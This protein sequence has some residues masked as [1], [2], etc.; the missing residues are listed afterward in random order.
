MPFTR[1]SLEGML[2]SADGDEHMTYCLSKYIIVP[3]GGPCDPLEYA[4]TLKDGPHGPGTTMRS[5]GLGSIRPG[6]QPEPCAGSTRLRVG[7]CPRQGTEGAFGCSLFQLLS[8]PVQCVHELAVQLAFRSQ[9]FVI[10]CH[11]SASAS[12][13]R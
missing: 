9:R 1:T 6:D 7:A 13:G 12:N 11:P 2:Y 8:G 4:S 10:P 5:K 3:S